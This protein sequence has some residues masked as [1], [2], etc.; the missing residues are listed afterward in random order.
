[1]S[2][3]TT[4]EQAKFL[5]A[6]VAC[7]ATLML[8]WLPGLAEAPRRLWLLRCSEPAHSRYAEGTLG[9]PKSSRSNPIQETPEVCEIGGPCLSAVHLLYSSELASGAQGLSFLF[10]L[11]VLMKRCVGPASPTPPPWA[12]QLTSLSLSLAPTMDH[13]DLTLWV[14]SE[15]V[16][17]PME[18]RVSAR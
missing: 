15:P 1:M 3:A 14:H 7:G 5:K 12:G 13:S 9:E 17:L 10:L 2:A 16:A 4:E 8:A 6:A 18:I 11:W